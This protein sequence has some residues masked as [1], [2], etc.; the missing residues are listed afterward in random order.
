MN[1]LILDNT[2]EA[3]IPY[4]CPTYCAKCSINCSKIIYCVQVQ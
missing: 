1:F 2:D 3:L 4:G